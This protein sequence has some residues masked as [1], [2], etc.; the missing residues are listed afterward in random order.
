MVDSGGSISFAGT[1]YRAGNQWI[2]PHVSVA[3]I[4]QRVQI[5]AGEELIKLHPI[6]HERA[7]E[8]GAYATPLGHPGRL[9]KKQRNTLSVKQVPNTNG[10]P[11]TEH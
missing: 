11:G 7:K 5:S 2:G 9:A 3:V 4:G 1:S 6:R 10:Q 8:L